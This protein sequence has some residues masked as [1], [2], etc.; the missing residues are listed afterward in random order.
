MLIHFA[1]ANG[2]PAQSYTPLLD[3]LAP[4]QV[5][6]LNK[7]GHNPAFP[8]TD[9]WAHLADELVDYLDQQNAE[10]V[11][12]VGHS[13]GALVSFIAACKYPQRFKAVLLLDPP[14]IF[15]VFTWVVRLAKL[16]GK[17]D[18]ITPAGKSKYRKSRWENRDM[19][20][21]YFA[22]KPLFRF[23][24]A[25]FDAFCE[26]VVSDKP[27]GSVELDYSVD[28]EV[29]IFRNVPHN[30]KQYNPPPNLPMKVIFGAQSDASQ[31][32]FI[33]PFCRHYGIPYQ[34]IQGQHMY[35]LQQPEMTSSLIHEFL[36]G[37]A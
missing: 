22:G 14:L 17:I 26:A 30:L 23:E 31:S 35:P 16:I 5:I 6:A 19:A 1:H 10:S 25:C 3:S 18:A 11:V 4:H 13:L 9:N 2:I 20:M 24:K 28:V 27:D 12:A 8:Y 36:D 33:L 34:L 29:G 37:I 32:P 21:E 7:L 15:G